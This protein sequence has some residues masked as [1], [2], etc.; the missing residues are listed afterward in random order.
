MSQAF[1]EAEAHDRSGDQLAALHVGEQIGAAGERHGAGAL[2]V[3]NAGGF[4]QCA[5]RTEFEK[6]QAHHELSTFSFSGRGFE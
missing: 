2:A 6:G 5:R 3:E 4:V 1:D